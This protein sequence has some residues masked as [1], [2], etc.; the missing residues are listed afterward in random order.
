MV[1]GHGAGPSTDYAGPDGVLGANPVGMSREDLSH[2][3]FGRSDMVLYTSM[4]ACLWKE[5]QRVT[6]ETQQAAL[7]TKCVEGGRKSAV[8]SHEEALFTKVGHQC[9]PTTIVR[10]T[11]ERG[12]L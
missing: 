11:I 7:I 4:Y 8:S 9:T 3:V 2:F 1:H 12:A 6:T 5:V 10:R